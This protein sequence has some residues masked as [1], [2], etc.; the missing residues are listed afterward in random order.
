MRVTESPTCTV[1]EEDVTVMVAWPVWREIEGW[2]T[3][4]SIWRSV[5][6]TYGD[7]W[8]SGCSTGQCIGVGHYTNGVGC[9][10]N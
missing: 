9:P 1:E 5:C 10:W 8:C 4:F 7:T 3:A 6:N 2:F